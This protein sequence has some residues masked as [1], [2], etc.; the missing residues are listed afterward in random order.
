LVESGVERLRIAIKK[1]I[2]YGGEYGAEYGFEEIKQRL[3]SE[4]R[5]TDREIEMVLKKLNRKEVKND[6]K[7]LKIKIDKAIYLGKKL[8]KR[9]EDILLI[10]VTGSVAAEYPKNNEDIDLMIITKRASLWITRLLVTMWIWMNKVPHRK[11]RTKEKRDQF[12]LNLWL[13][14]DSLVLPNNRRNLNNA[15]D[16]ILMKPVINKNE[17]YGRFIKE[18][19]WAEKYVATGYDKIITN[20]P[21]RGF[22]KAQQITNEKPEKY[23]LKNLINRIV[24][25]L[26][27]IYMRKKIRKETVDLKRAFFY[28][29]NR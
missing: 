2:D 19:R 4:K 25:G 28:P 20:Y 15:M 8:A 14:E 26:Q 11:N 18:N 29:K 16:L 27:Y 3:I 17:V 22:R 9:F 24:F 23:I 6:N 13:E 10:G 21:T 12:C 1:T 5:Y 7:Y